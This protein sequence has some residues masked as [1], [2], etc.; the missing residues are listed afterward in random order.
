MS[1]NGNV[2]SRI[3]LTRVLLT[4]SI[5]FAHVSQSSPLLGTYGFVNWL[6]VFLCEGLTRIGVPCLSAISGYIPFRRGVADFAH[7][8]V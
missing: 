8:K 7:W 2:S 4:S 3:Y 6:R 1:M 5:V